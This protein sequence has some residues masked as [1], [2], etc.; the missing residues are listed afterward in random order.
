MW[1]KILMCIFLLLSDKMVLFYARKRRYLCWNL[2]LSQTYINICEGLRDR[3]V[4]PTFCSVMISHVWKVI[5]AACFTGL[6]NETFSSIN[7]H[8]TKI[9]RTLISYQYP[10]APHLRLTPPSFHIFPSNSA[11]PFSPSPLS[12]LPL[13]GLFLSPFA[14]HKPT[15]LTYFHVVA[16]KLTLQTNR[17]E[18]DYRHAG[19]KKIKT[20]GVGAGRK[21]THQGKSVLL[22]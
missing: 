10:A 21:K 20:E 9:S 19:S 7:R 11:T 12:P 3:L 17:A 18:A 16:G 6:S 8:K 13:S 22:K 5:C 15:T 14:T 1:W 2:K 4:G